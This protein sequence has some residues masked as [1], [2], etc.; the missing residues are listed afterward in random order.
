MISFEE[1]GRICMYAAIDDVTF[2]A[3]LIESAKK[4]TDI[5]SNQLKE[6]QEWEEIVGWLGSEMELCRAKGFIK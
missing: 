3:K 6:L 4:M 5:H 1:L 2:P